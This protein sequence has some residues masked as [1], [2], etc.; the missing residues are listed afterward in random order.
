MKQRDMTVVL[1]TLLVAG[2][3]L[4]VIHLANQR[5]EKRIERDRHEQIEQ[6]Q[7]LWDQE[8]GY[9]QPRGM[10]RAEI[11]RRYG[12][13]VRNDTSN[14]DAYFVVTTTVGRLMTMEVSFDTNDLATGWLFIN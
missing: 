8:V 14:N 4:S 2:M 10:T 13:L 6:A 5:R 7:E 12:K 11:E 3:V 9:I 1:L